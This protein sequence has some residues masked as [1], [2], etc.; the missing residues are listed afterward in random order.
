MKATAKALKERSLDLFKKAL[1][2]YHERTLPLSGENRQG[3]VLIKGRT[4]TRPIDP[5]ASLVAVR[6]P[7]G[8][9]FDPG[10]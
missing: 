6:H 8:A 3:V 10:R 4:A 2:E 7:V 9:K 1:K 5:N